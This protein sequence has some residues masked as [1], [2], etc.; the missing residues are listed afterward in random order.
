MEAL[1]GGVALLVVGVVGI[2]V[3]VQDVAGR[4]R[5]VGQLAALVVAVA[6]DVAQGIG[7]ADGAARR[8]SRSTCGSSQV[9]PAISRRPAALGKRLENSRVYWRN[10]PSSRS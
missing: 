10:R 8:I 6:R 9:S 4:G 7:D 3:V 2:V 1:G 5:L